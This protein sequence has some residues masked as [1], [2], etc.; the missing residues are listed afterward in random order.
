MTYE[1]SSPVI[2]KLGS[3]SFLKNPMTFFLFHFCANKFFPFWKF[4][5][6]FCLYSKNVRQSPIY[7]LFYF[8]SFIFVLSHSFLL[9]NVFCFLLYIFKVQ[10]SPLSG[11]I[12]QPL[13]RP[14]PS[15]PLLCQALLG[16]IS[17]ATTTPMLTS[18]GF[19]LS[20]VICHLSDH[21]L[22]HSVFLM[23][24]FHTHLKCCFSWFL[25]WLCFHLSHNSVLVL[26]PPTLSPLECQICS[27]LDLAYTLTTLEI[28][29]KFLSNTK[30]LFW[31]MH[32]APM[33]PSPNS[34]VSTFFF[35][36]ETNHTFLGFVDHQCQSQ[37]F[38]SAVGAQKQP[39][40]LVTEWACLHP[41]KTSVAKTNG[42]RMWPV[43]ILPPKNWLLWS[44]SIPPAE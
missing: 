25:S 23:I 14:F 36:T 3:C 38:H 27:G 44:V 18:L 1:S 32:T 43:L 28:I 5:L 29:P 8:F 12:F 26:L 33:V 31:A 16:T 7:F 19:T 15:R 30:W 13:L 6:L 41:H 2:W 37:L 35:Y 34:G 40:T 11:Q 22:S 39:Q 21:S 4:L 20:R 10:W 42:G 17:P 9:I 24:L